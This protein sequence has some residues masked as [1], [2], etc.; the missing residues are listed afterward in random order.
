LEIT[1][2]CWGA[3]VDALKAEKVRYV[4]GIPSDGVQLYADLA[5]A[6]E[7]QPILVRHETSSVFMAMGYSRITNQPAACYASPGPG[8]ANLVPGLLEAFSG[9]TPVIALGSAAKMQTDQMGAFQEND[10]ITMMRPVTK[11]A[12]RITRPDKAGWTMNRAFTL[13]TNGRPGPIYID[14][15]KDVG[16]EQVEQPQY[17]L[18][19]KYVRVAPDPKLINDA[20]KLI[21]KANAPIVVAGGGVILS[22]AFEELRHFCEMTA[23]PVFT[24]PSGRGSISED[25]PLAM[26]LLGLYRTRVNKKTYESADLVINLGSRTEEFQ[27]GEWKFYPSDANLVQVDIDPTAIGRN[28]TPTLAIIGDIRLVLAEIIGRI[29]TN[30]AEEFADVP[31]IQEILKLKKDYENE[32]ESECRP[33]GSVVKTKQVIR[34]LNKVFGH[35][36][37]LVNENG[38]QDIWSYYCPYY[39]LLDI[40][41]CVP[42]AEQTCMG[43]GVAASIG[44]KLAAPNKKVVCTTGDG[45]FQ[46]FMKEIATAV[47][48]NAPVTWTIFNSF[49][50]HWVKYI[51]RGLGLK[52][53]GVDFTCN[54]DFTK[55]AEAYKCY[56]LRIERPSDIRPALQAA[57][58]SNQ[59]GVP[60]ILDFIVD[61]W[62]YPKGFIEFHEKVW[63]IPSPKQSHS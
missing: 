55:I 62:D 25:H 4:F 27:S 6:P 24:T 1:K 43:F 3:I 20:V 51:Q 23:T 44:A 21:A 31:R 11:W 45:A 63:G 12:Y 53:V 9:C 36:T 13:A 7:V 58:K 14:V 40:N 28:W 37:F 57:L 29:E 26:G 61:P 59:D 49:S 47:Q 42:P 52:E 10:Q 5:E 48:Y 34:E 41:C 60:A 46:M 33:Q 19:T 38:S 2:T 8:V 30:I 15:P 32:I 35:D 54:P 17:K 16:M 56:G 22:Q 39:K 50:L 18:A